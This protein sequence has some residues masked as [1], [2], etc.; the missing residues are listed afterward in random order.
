M[1]LNGIIPSYLRRSFEDVRDE[2]EGENEVSLISREYGPV[3][4]TFLFRN[5]I[6]IPTPKNSNFFNLKMSDL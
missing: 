2:G 4:S 5:Q 6:P 3:E 1:S